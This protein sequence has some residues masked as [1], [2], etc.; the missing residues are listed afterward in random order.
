MLIA[1]GAD[2][3]VRDGHRFTPLHDAL[4]GGHPDVA[5]VL[6]EAGADPFLKTV[7]GRRSEQGIMN[8]QNGSRGG[9]GDG[10]AERRPQVQEIE[11]IVG[12]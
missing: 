12:G 7:D 5:K 4:Q 9:T 10:G 1:A 11:G 2:M 8:F 3:N 6:V